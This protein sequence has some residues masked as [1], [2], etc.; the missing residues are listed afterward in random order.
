LTGGTVVTLDPDRP[1]AQAVAARGDSIVCVG[2]AEDCGELA[3]PETRVIDLSGRT[4]L[5]GLADSHLHLSGVGFREMELNL[6]GARGLDELLAAVAKR[7]EGAK[8]G[9]WIT[10]R[11]WIEAQWD[12][13]K[14]PT[15]ADL[16]GVSP[17]NPVYLVRADGH[18]G[19]ANSK[20]LEIAG[21]DGETTVPEGGDI[22]RDEAGKP[23]GMLIDR[24]QTL[25]RRHMPQPSPDR[26]REA[27]GRGARHLARMGWTQVSIAG[28]SWEEIA[29]V[30]RL[31]DET[32]I[33][34]RVYVAAAGPGE[35][36]DRLLARGAK[37]R[38]DGRLTVRGIKVVMD[39]ALGSRGAALEAPD[40]DDPSTSGLLMHEPEDIQPMLEEALRK[41]VQV[42]IHAIGDRAN[43]VV[44]DLYEQAFAAVP[45]AKRAIA[46]PRWRIEHA[47]ILRPADIP[48]FAA[49]GVIPS[50]Q[51]SHA[52]T[53]L[54]FAPSRLGPERL[55]G[56]Y[57]WRSLVDAGSKI[58]G[59]S[60]APVERGDPRV[61][62]YAAS[63]RKDLQGFSN[64]D[65]HGEQRL[66]PEEALHTLTDWAALAT[67]EE[68]KRGTI[69]V[70][71]WADFTVFSANPLEAP[72]AEI[73][74]MNVELTIVGGRVVYE[75][76]QR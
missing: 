37:T 39:G 54:H 44:L 15:A 43:H 68:D 38:R 17:D 3:G 10:G 5:P 57:A 11:G 9:E 27:L 6:E 14:F 48:R 4:I 21:I 67:F 28:A 24:A 74:Q 12:P 58:A 8:A 60:D 26:L 29:Q 59:G 30:E 46:A 61:E 75:A 66:T 2:S 69:E 22:L 1:K 33:G 51:A 62:L 31:I 53:D 34:I 56:A 47:Q 52:I 20:A 76:G 63:A 64:A 65:W 19:V 36:A 23:S 50:M 49:L 25:V 18:A 35:D 45:E 7:V 41:G 16:D 55:A 70:G 40:S 73:L 42:E 32:L 71:K 72:E 13:P